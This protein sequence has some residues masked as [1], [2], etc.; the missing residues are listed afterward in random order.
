MPLIYHPNPILKGPC[1]E[2]TT[3][4]DARFTYEVISEAIRFD[5]TWGVCVGLAAN[6]AMLKKRAFIAM[7]RYFVNPRITF[8]SKQTLMS[9]E[10]CYSLKKGK[11]FTVMRHVEIDLHYQDIN[12]KHH[13][14]SFDGRMATVIQHEMDHL[15][16]KTLLETA[17]W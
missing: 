5:C 14:E 1:Q 10:G 8:R 16:G 6:Q 7:D 17:R 2:I 3:K 11:M 4:E 9:K 13:Q 12:L 15:D